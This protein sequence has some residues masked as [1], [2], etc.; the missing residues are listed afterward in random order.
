MHICTQ[1]ESDWLYMKHRKKNK[2]E[3]IMISALEWTYS[4]KAKM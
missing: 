3:T 1:F 4:L 2:V